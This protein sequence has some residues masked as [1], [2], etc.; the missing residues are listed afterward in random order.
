MC[1]ARTTADGTLWFDPFR[2]GYYTAALSVQ[3]SNAERVQ[4]DVCC[5]RLNAIPSAA[6][7]AA[8]LIELGLSL[9]SVNVFIVGPIPDSFGDLKAMAHLDLSSNQLS[10]EHG[11]RVLRGAALRYLTAL[12]VVICIEEWRLLLLP[13]SWPTSSRGHDMCP[14]S[15]S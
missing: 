15:W 13:T 11:V 12:R 4:D 7:R 2:H 8:W 3:S 1:G 5:D 6:S 9:A 14:Q 10:G